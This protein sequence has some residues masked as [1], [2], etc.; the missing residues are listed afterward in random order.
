MKITKRQLRRIIRSEQR[1]LLESCGDSPELESIEGASPLDAT[2]AIAESQEPEGELVMEME[3]A[4]RNLEL[5][6]ESINK[7]SSLCP[8]CVHEVAAAAPLIEA[9]VSQASALQETIEAVGVIVTEGSAMGVAK[10]LAD[11]SFP[12]EDPLDSG[13]DPLKLGIN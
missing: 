4:S 9:M 8:T 6:I 2:I 3:M 13:I 7:A 11:I 1:R 5:A 12:E 10:E